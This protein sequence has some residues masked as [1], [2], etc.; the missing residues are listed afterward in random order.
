M[1]TPEFAVPTLQM[2]IDEGHTISAVVTQPDRPK[3]RGNKE[4]MS[5]VKMLALEHNLEVLQPE[6]IRGDEVF[7]NHIKA[8]NPDVIVVVAFG[9]ILPVEVL[10]LPP[11]G[12]INIHGSLLPQYRGAAPIQWSIINGDT[13]TGVTIMYMDKGMDTGDMIHKVEMPI[14]TTDTYQSL[15][16]KMK[17]IGA[18]ALR[19]AWPLIAKGEQREKQADEEATYAPMIHKGLG[20]IDWQQP[21]QAI[22]CLIR[23]VNPWPGAYTYYEG[24]V[25]KIWEASYEQTQTTHQAGEVVKVDKDGICVQTGDGIITVREIQAP[26][27]KRMPVSEYIKGHTIEVGKLLGN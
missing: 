7:Y 22:D 16:D 26:N 5:P 10:E 2:L 11:L 9:Q 23:G 3:G 4:V 21:S 6:R 27:K 14:A 24:Q 15:H 1:G 17:T 25:F 19:E 13:T 18:D 20:E 8:L 12:S